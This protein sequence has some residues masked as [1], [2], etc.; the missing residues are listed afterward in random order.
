MGYF[1]EDVQT[2]DDDRSPVREI[3]SQP[4]PL[5]GEYNSDL[6]WIPRVKAPQKVVKVGGSMV[7]VP[8][9]KSSRGLVAVAAAAA[10]VAISKAA[11]VVVADVVIPL[12]LER[13]DQG[14]THIRTPS[15]SPTYRNHKESPYG[16]VDSMYSVRY[17]NNE[18][19]PVGRDDVPPSVVCEVV[20]VVVIK[21]P[22]FS[23]KNRFPRGQ[24]VPFLLHVVLPYTHVKSPLL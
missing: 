19:L 12:S 14:S 9:R 1:N 13:Q 7:V 22:L 16:S 24:I 21:Q 20:P 3:R 5:S 17:E 2:F 23:L 18:P 4:V 15:P 6:E 10:A 11:V 8:T